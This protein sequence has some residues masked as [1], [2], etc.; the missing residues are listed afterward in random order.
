[1]T[2]SWRSRL[3]ASPRSPP[4]SPRF[5]AAELDLEL[6]P[7]PKLFLRKKQRKQVPQPARAENLE[8]GAAC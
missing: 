3:P 5:T 4:L 1:M 7:N 8:A 6:Q 2:S